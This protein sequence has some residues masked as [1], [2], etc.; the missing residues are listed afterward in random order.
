MEYRPLGDALEVVA[1]RAIL[2]EACDP[3]PR[4]LLVFATA[5]VRCNGVSEELT[6][7]RGCLQFWSLG[8]V[9]DDGDLGDGACGS[10]AEGAGELRRGNGATGEEGRHLSFSYGVVWSV[11]FPME[12]SSSRF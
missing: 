10:A 4:R 11:I 7:G 5:L 2:L 8:Q 12:L 6:T 1:T 9:T 3:E